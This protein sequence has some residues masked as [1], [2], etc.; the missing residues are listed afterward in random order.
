MEGAAPN[1]GISWWISVTDRELLTLLAQQFV[2]LH[3]LAASPGPILCDGKSMKKWAAVMNECD[4]ARETIL[5]HLE[6]D[7]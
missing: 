6:N 4:V 1:A 2:L 3:R 7:D 5:K